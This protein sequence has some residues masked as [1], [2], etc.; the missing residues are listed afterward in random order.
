MKIYYFYHG[1]YSPSM[2]IHHFFL[3]PQLTS[4]KHYEALRMYFIEQASPHEVAKAFGFTPRAVT[5]LVSDFKKALQQ[6]QADDSLFFIRKKK[7]RPV[8]K[9]QPAMVQRVVAFRKK[10]HSVEDIKISLDAM[11][12]PISER[13]I[14]NILKAEG[15]AR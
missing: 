7:G 12:E 13:S 8:S 10:N 15:F 4:H 11:G 14:Q 2:D 3:K 1:N 9:S 5:S 6:D